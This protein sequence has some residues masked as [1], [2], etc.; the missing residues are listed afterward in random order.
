MADEARVEE[1]LEELLD[2]GGTPEEVCRGCPELLAQ[3]RAGWQRLR[4]VVAEVGAWFPQSTAD[5]AS[6]DGATPRP[7]PNP[8]LPPIRGY[9]VQAMLGRSGM[10]VVYKAWHLRLKRPVA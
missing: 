7:R 3:V 4:A 8:D 9:E 6:P 1:L 10:G 2:S 5:S